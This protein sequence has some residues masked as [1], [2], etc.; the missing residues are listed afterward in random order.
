MDPS[1]FQ[2]L[3]LR[4]CLLLVERKPEEL[5]YEFLNKSEL[6]LL[7]LSLNDGILRCKTSSTPSLT[8]SSESSSSSLIYSCFFSSSEYS[9]SSSGILSIDSKLCLNFVLLCCERT[10]NYG[11]AVGVPR[12]STNEA[13]DGL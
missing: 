9:S 5:Y 10:D 11:V 12:F 8:G 6:D 13:L 3:R 7:S 4:G 2:I 1:K